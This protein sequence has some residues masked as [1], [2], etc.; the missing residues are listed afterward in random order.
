[1]LFVAFFFWAAWSS[2]LSLEKEEEEE[3]PLFEPDEEPEEPEEPPE[4]LEDCAW[5]YALSLGFD[6]GFGL[7]LDSSTL[8]LS[9]PLAM[10]GFSILDSS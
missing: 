7:L 9:S 5:P 6:A 8:G 10:A 4:E 3:L 1:M 2:S